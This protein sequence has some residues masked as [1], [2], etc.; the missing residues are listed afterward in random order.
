M[1]RAP[2]IT[3]AKH[4]PTPA[5]SELEAANAPVWLIDVEGGRIL[6]ASAAGGA[7][8][9]LDEGASLRPDPSDSPPVLDAA[10]PALT[11]LR[12]LAAEAAGPVI[13]RLVFWTRNGATP[14]RCRVEIRRAGPRV[15][16]LVTAI[17]DA[18]D[19]ALV[20]PPFTAAVPLAGDDAAKLKEIARR[21]REGQVTSARLDRR[22]QRS[23]SASAAPAPTL[24]ATAAIPAEAPFDAEPEL[25]AHLRASLAHEL[26]TPVSAIAAAAEIMKDE[27]FGPLGST[28]YVGY[29][30]DI[31]GSAQHVLGLIDRMLAEGATLDLRFPNLE[32]AELDAGELL[33][34]SVSQLMPLAERA[35]IALTLDLAP[36]LPHIIADATSLRQIVFNLVTNALKFTDRGGQVTVATRYTGDGPLVIVVADTGAG[37]PQSEVERLLARDGASPPARRGHAA[38][39]VGLGLGLPLVAALAAANG[40]ALRLESAPGQGTAASIVFAKERVVPV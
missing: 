2:I 9:G 8:L 34:V 35:G 20:D 24:A 33:Q 21:I 11:R 6:A 15:L 22:K 25:P 32:F 18:V 5:L 19:G 26:K 38:G 36:R 39:A 4:V 12:T 7:L 1:K 30:A 16:A 40:A 13:E 10:M 3:Y 17:A 27:R 31:L 23:V 29:A 14:A 28:R 37:M